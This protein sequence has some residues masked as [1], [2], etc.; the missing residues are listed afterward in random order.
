MLKKIIDNEEYNRLII[1]RAELNQAL[2]SR[3]NIGMK[4]SA[5]ESEL[6]EIEINLPGI[7][8]KIEAKILEETPYQV[9]K[10]TMTAHLQLEVQISTPDG[11]QLWPLKQYEDSFQL[12]DSV[13]PPDLTSDEPQERM[14]DPLTLP[15]E[16]KFK[17]QALDYVL[18]NNIIPDILENF[19]NYGM[20]FY[21]KAVELS[22]PHDE[23]KPGS[24]A[25]LDSIEEYYKFLACYEDKGE[26]DTL[27]E[28]VQE[29]L[30]KYI[31][32][33]WLVHKR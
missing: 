29:D 15:S 2:I 6:K 11:G 22:K 28:M 30:K 1:R 12:E 17:E 25:F 19:E 23:V 10:H 21:L 26:E 5:I 13:V 24:P 33:L 31:S 7:S 18:E 16:S 8:P 14:G 4:K 27:P 9:V 20:R 32:T 3:K